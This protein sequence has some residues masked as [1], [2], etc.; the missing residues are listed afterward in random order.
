MEGLEDGVLVLEEVGLVLVEVLRR[1]LVGPVAVVGVQ[2]DVLLLLEGIVVVEV[3]EGEEAAVEEEAEDVEV[4]EEA[5]GAEE[6]DESGIIACMSL[7]RR[8][9]WFLNGMYGYG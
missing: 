8:G 4:V 9:A 7:G 2:E 1:R 6:V 5:A 3:A